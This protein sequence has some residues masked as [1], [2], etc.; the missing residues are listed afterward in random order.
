MRNPACPGNDPTGEQ[1]NDELTDRIG[2]LAKNFFNSDFV[3]AGRCSTLT[4]FNLDRDLETVCALFEI[5]FV[6]LSDVSKLRVG[7]T[8]ACAC[9]LHQISGCC[10]DDGLGLPQQFKSKKRTFLLWH[11]RHEATS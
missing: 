9:D 2:Q 8:Q 5:V 11:H 4:S 10:V 6:S 1:A 3:S 7:E